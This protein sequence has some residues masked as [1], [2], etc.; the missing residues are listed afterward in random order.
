MTQR[1]GWTLL[2]T[3]IALGIIAVLMSIMI[4]VLRSVLGKSGM[5]K[6][7]ANMSLTMKDFFSWS[8][9]N[10]GRMLNKGLPPEDNPYGY[11]TQSQTWP[12]VL[13]LAFGEA[14]PYWQSTYANPEPYLHGTM[15]LAE[16][17]RIEPG[18]EWH[19]PS[20]FHYSVTMLT[21][22]KSW[23]YPGLGLNDVPDFAKYYAYILQADI[24]YPSNKG[25]LWHDHIEPGPGRQ[26]LVAFG[27][28]SVSQ[29]DILSAKPSAAYPTSHDVNKRW[30]PIAGTL[31]GALGQDF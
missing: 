4:P 23:Q 29:R 10:K 17:R 6:N 20:D 3:L 12:D 21:A 8:N 24:A 14:E 1:R 26:R 22:P 19:A 27:D 2:E 28:G 5:T 25:V 18:W 7:Q 31:H 11:I 16:A 9:S 13:F 15:T 30:G